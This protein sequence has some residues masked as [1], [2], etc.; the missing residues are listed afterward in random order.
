[1][2]PT[3]VVGYDG[4]ASAKAALR[5]AARRAGPD[6]E[7]VIAHAV[8]VAT[9]PA[10]WWDSRVYADIVKSANAAAEKMLAAARDDLGG[11]GRVRTRLAT[12]PAPYAL[13]EVAAAADADEIVVGTR[14]LGPV[15]SLLGSVSHALLHVARRPVT[16]VRAVEPARETEGTSVVVGYDGSP[17]SGAA[18]AY[19]LEHLAGRRLY[20][21]SAA[22]P[23]PPHLGKPY[24]QQALDAAIGRARHCAAEAA[25][26]I[27]EHIDFETEILAERPA[28][29][30]LNVAEVRGSDEI[31]VGSR[32][33]GA[34]RG[35]LGSTSHELIRRAPCPVVVITE[36]AADVQSQVAGAA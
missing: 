12:G 32:G 19:A 30:L 25:D 11:E 4:S 13:E 24:M 18:L 20:V 17:P 14:G 23:V 26:G 1:M 6:G 5:L 15:S 16:V 28:D 33:F 35:S 31:V 22:E 9:P 36:Q 27:P 3:I 29:A 34:L 21:V 8:E 10:E 2:S 7:V